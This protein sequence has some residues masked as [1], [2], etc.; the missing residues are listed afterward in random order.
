M[1][2]YIG[3]IVLLLLLLPI[4]ICAAGNSIVISGTDDTIDSIAIPKL[5]N[6]INGELFVKELINENDIAVTYEKSREDIIL[7]I[8]EEI[9]GSLK[10]T[11]KKQFLSICLEE[12]QESDISNVNK[13][14]VYN[15][16]VNS[17]SKISGLIVNMS[18]DIR[19]DIPGAKNILKPTEN[20][21]SIIL[22]LVTIIIF[23]ALGL[24]IVMDV[25]YITIPAMQL[26]IQSKKDPINIRPIIISLEAW[27]AVKV[28]EISKRAALG[29][30]FRNKVGQ[31]IVLGIC[32][33][34]LVSGNIYSLVAYIIDMMHGV[35]DLLLN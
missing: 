30:Y 9:Y 10:Q 3:V 24:S 29:I 28:A 34:Y 27:D 35:T 2:K 22:G 26:L 6:N 4:R 13:T 19:V 5:I 33:L 14:K 20:P 8:N 32:I 23:V 18:E 25:G 12:T 16:F 7:D 31:L 15:F 1:K 17:D 21:I 11:E